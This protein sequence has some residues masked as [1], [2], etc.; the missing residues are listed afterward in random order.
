ML[1]EDWWPGRRAVRVGFNEKEAFAGN[2]RQ[3]SKWIP[4]N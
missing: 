2:K 4:G 3:I 1:G